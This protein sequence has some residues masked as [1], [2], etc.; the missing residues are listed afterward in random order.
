M[1][2]CVCKV[3]R[4][5]IDV[6]P[7]TAKFSADRFGSTSAKHLPRMS[8]NSSSGLFCSL[9]KYVWLG[10]FAPKPRVTLSPN[11]IS[12]TWRSL[13]GCSKSVAGTTGPAGPSPTGRR[14]K[15]SMYAGTD[16]TVTT[17]SSNNQRRVRVGGGGLMEFSRNSRF[18]SRR[19]ESARAQPVVRRG[20][21][22]SGARGEQASFLHHG[23]LELDAD[24]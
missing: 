12:R 19:H 8:A 1:G 13:Q 9:A 24:W 10:D 2:T 4:C 17:P 5:S 22:E 15:N 7:E 20:G 23:C 6:E 14:R 18:S 11:P 3:C 16:I 21:L